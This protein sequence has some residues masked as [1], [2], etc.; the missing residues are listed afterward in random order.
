[1]LIVSEVDKQ[2]P[3]ETTQCVHVKPVQSSYFSV[4]HSCSRNVTEVKSFILK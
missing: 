2:K 1:M 4:D 3:D